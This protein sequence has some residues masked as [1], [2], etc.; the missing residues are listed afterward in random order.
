L[1]R[2]EEQTFFKFESKKDYKAVLLNFDDHTFIKTVLD[3]DSLEYFTKN[4]AN[5]K[6][7][8]SKAMIWSSLADMVRDSELKVD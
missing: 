2:N 4:I 3:K 5:L 7:Q 8:I 1:L 6:D